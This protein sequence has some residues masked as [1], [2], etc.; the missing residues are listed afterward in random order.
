MANIPSFS[1]TIEEDIHFS[2]RFQ[3]LPEPLTGRTFTMSINEGPTNVSKVVLSTGDGSLS[4]DP[5]QPDTIKAFYAKAN[6]AGWRVGIEYSADLIETTG[7]K[8]SRLIPIRL[9]YSLPPK[10]FVQPLYRSINA[11]WRDAVVYATMAG[12][13]GPRGFSGDGSGDMVAA[14]NLADLANVAIARENLGL[15]GAARLDVGTTAGTVAAG[16]DSRFSFQQTGTGAVVRSLLDKNRDGLHIKDFGAKMDGVTDDAAAI[17]AAINEAALRGKAVLVTGGGV[18]LIKDIITMRPN[19][20]LLGDRKTTIKQGD[21]AD[22]SR[23]I[24]GWPNADNS[25][26]E[27]LIVDGNRANNPTSIANSALIH[28]DVSNYMEVIGNHVNNAPSIAIAMGPGRGCAVERNIVYNRF[29]TAIFVNVAVFPSVR[30]N[31]VE[32]GGMYGVSFG[33]C[34]KPVFQGNILNGILLTGLT[35]S[36]SGTTVT[37]AAGTTFDFVVPGLHMCVDGGREYT[38]ASVTDS[39]HL[40]VTETMVDLVNVPAIIGNGDGVGIISCESGKF[41]DNVVIGCVSFGM[42]IS[43]AF[44]GTS[45]SQNIIGRN[46]IGYTGKCG[47]SLSWNESGSAMLSNQAVDNHFSSTGMG[48]VPVG[49]LDRTA[50]TVFDQYGEFELNLLIDGNHVDCP[51]ADHWLAFN[52]TL[53]ANS[54]RLG[55]NF[56]RIVTNPDI[57]YKDVK[58]ITLDAGW[59][60]TATVTDI[61]S[62][63][64]GVRFT[65]NASGTGFAAF[66]GFNISKICGKPASELSIKSVSGGDLFIGEHNSTFGQWKG[67]IVGTPVNGGTYVIQMK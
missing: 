50:I 54:I 38:V 51:S 31:T 61:V 7:G 64:N 29:S 44:D 21:G 17:N 60:S 4:V 16:D 35:V 33:K 47:L 13:R 14:A 37:A 2:I 41:I 43:P 27:G 6:T 32:G 56:G 63:G 9:Q 58:A 8:F 12:E 23:M 3:D 15:G 18:C 49:E 45:C 25:R 22:L 66:A 55:T 52:D 65:I 39:T 34:V 42:G 1:F 30:F 59:G 11:H 5:A 57:V 46:H 40:E 20:W 24:S 67:Q 48:G 62:T 19:V 28:T 53:N 10:T 26:V 36:T